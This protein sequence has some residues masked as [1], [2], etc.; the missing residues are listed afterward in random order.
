MATGIQAKSGARSIEQAQRR[1]EM[2]RLRLEGLTLEEIAD[3]MGITSGTVQ[4]II[5]NTLTTMVKGPADELRALELARCDELME[6]AMQ[7]VRAFHPLIAN[8]KVVSAPMLDEQG[9]PVRNPESGDVLTQVLEDKQPKLAAVACAIRVMERRARL[10]GLDAPTRAQ[11]ELT[12]VNEAAGPDLSHLT[13][14]EL[15]SIK[16]QLYG[17]QP[18]LVH[19]PS[20]ITQ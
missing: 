8:G 17:G 3:H 14:H 13:V 4:R 2:M 19:Q 20:E 16:A 15:E 9:R 10:L 7:T 6:E 12:V 18:L 5:A 1:T 11:Q